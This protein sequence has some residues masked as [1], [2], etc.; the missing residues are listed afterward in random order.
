MVQLKRI[1]RK[2]QNRLSYSLALSPWN[3]C[4]KKNGGKI[5]VAKFIFFTQ[6]LCQ[7]NVVVLVNKFTEHY[8]AD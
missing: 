4:V 3:P 2:K 6:M 7:F 1:V 8:L 5:C